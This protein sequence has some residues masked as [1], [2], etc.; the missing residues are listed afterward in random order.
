MDN[1][2]KVE[3]DWIHS[4]FILRSPQKLEELA[5]VKIA[6]RLWNKVDISE[7]NEKSN[8][9]ETEIILAKL[10]VKE[11]IHSMELPEFYEEILLQKSELI[12]K[13][14][15]DLVLTLPSK[16]R[17]LQNMLHSLSDKIC[18]TTQGTIDKTTTAKALADATALGVKMRFE[19]AV[20]FC[21]ED[22]VNALSIKMPKD[23]LKNNEELR[24]YINSMHNA[25][26]ARKHF[27]IFWF[28]PSYAECFRGML[29]MS[30]FS[31]CQYFWHYL[32]NEKKLSFLESSYIIDASNCYLLF[33]F[34]QFDN[35]RRLQI[36]Q[37]EKYCCMLAKQLLNL[38]WLFLFDA[39]VKDALRLLTIDSVVEI[40]DESADK[41]F[42]E[43]P[44]E[45]TYLRICSMLLKFL[46][47]DCSITTL[48][49]KTND[50]MVHAMLTLMQ[51]EK[52]KSRS[53]KH[54]VEVKLVKTF[55]ESVS[56]DWIRK[57]Y[58]LRS[59]NFQEFIELSVRFELLE[60]IISSAFPDIEERKTAID[61][62]V[63]DSI[64]YELFVQ[65]NG[66]DDTYRILI[67]IFSDIDDIE[68]YKKKLVEE[69]GCRFF[70]RFFEYDYWEAADKFIYW[71]FYTEEEMLAF[72]NKFFKSESFGSL[73]DSP[74]FPL[75]TALSLIK[76]NKLGR[77]LS[78]VDLLLDVC[79]TILFQCYV[80]FF[81]ADENASKR[82]FDAL[83]QLLL[84]FTCNDQDKLIDLKKQLLTYKSRKRHIPLALESLHE[85]VNS[86]FPCLNRVD[87][88]KLWREMIEDFFSWIFSSDE[89]QKV[90]MKNKFWDSKVIIEAER[91]FR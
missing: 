90:K 76:I 56:N 47:K 42:L 32:N 89:K 87:K 12:V 7:E 72:Y 52:V 84:A 49:S 30:N 20:N 61:E 58:S 27:K 59:E 34:T 66:K 50:L 67:I 74:T 2:L 48:G 68:N 51:N 35:E 44:Y 75:S 4:K 1:L 77:L 43:T 26:I 33:L 18:W 22:R 36:L 69:R 40:L 45:K 29:L 54:Q 9:I 37:N 79:L 85:R 82:L 15:N 6:L 38:E 5:S 3:Y 63:I 31:A 86:E 10:K 46:S 28:V 53:Y 64:I 70:S 16:F 65:A 23:Y 19:I 21:L 60:Y 25:S 80:T 39:C 88:V 81:Y 11:N 41:L 57:L 55:L 13:E 24:P 78:N 71:C 17:D 83:D 8:E 91:R 62:S 73:F 14:W